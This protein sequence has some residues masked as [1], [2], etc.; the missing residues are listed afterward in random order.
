MRVCDVP[1]GEDASSSISQNIPL[2]LLVAIAPFLHFDAWHYFF[3]QGYR[4]GTKMGL[5]QAILGARDLE[6]TLEELTDLH[7][8]WVLGVEEEESWLP[9]SEE[10]GEEEIK[11]HTEDEYE[12]EDSDGIDEPSQYPYCEVVKIFL[13]V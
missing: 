1:P 7:K 13:T 5:D 10:L 11:A 6:E 3:G 8:N 4:L 12:E 9:E 2:L